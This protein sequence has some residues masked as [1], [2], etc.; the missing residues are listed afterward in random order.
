M[1][2]ETPEADLVKLQQT[3][4][5]AGAIADPDCAMSEGGRIRALF[6]LPMMVPR[7]ESE[8][9]LEGLGGL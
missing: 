5:P 1:D 7:T 3:V 9:G 2:S 6:L 8:R 4:P